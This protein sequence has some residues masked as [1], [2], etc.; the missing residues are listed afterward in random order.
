MNTRKWLTVSGLVALAVLALAVGL[1]QAQGPEPPEGQ[2]GVE[3]EVGAAAVVYGRIPIQGRLTDAG[4]N[5]LNGTYSIRFNLYDAAT[6]GSVVW[7]TT[8]SVEVNNGLFNSEIRDLISSDINGRQLYL[9]IKVGTDDE[10]TPRQA[11]YPVPYAFSLVP[12]AIISDTRSG[13]A[14]LHIENW[15]A[16]GRGLRVYAMD[17][18]GANF[19]IVGASRSPA[20]YGGYFY[21]NSA[22]G[23]TGLRA[24]S[25]AAVGLEGYSYETADYPGVFGCSADSSGTCDPYKDDNAAGVMGYSDNDWGGY[26]VGND[27]SAGGVYGTSTQG[28]GVLGVSQY[29]YGVQAASGANHALYAGSVLSNGVYAYSLGAGGIGVYGEAASSSGGIGVEGSSEAGSGVYGHSTEGYGVYGLTELASNNY[30]FFTPDNLYSLNYNLMGAIMQVVQNSGEK[31][32]ELGDVVAFSGIGASLEA[33]GPPVIQV[34]GAA[35]ADS[36][37]VAG[38]VYSRFNIEA[39]TGDPKELNLEVTPEGLVQPGEYMLMVIQ[40]PAQVK[41]SAL[42]GSLQPGDLLSSAGQAG[43][44]GKAAEVTLGG[45]KT[46]MPGTVLGKALEPL[47]E[48]QAMIYV[49]VTL[50]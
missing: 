29:G 44:A 10:M 48:G 22:G 43:Y 41:A 49:F 9:G 31:T 2:V 47:N 5:P 11:I 37:A 27:S 39:V 4:G 30:G 46:A 26:F 7:G 14:I 1:T 8:S 28:K 33:G 24:W 13:N 17:E 18:T 23:G 36:T 20:G 50:Q 21:N 15:G 40:G 32:L 25:E 35:S 3:G 6:D 34:T 42:A 12:G 16:T 38:V 19:G 45:V